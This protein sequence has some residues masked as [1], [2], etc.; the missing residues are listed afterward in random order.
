MDTASWRKD[1][2]IQTEEFFD[3]RV[4][5]YWNTLPAEVVQAASL[6]AFKTRLNKY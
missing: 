3:K 2:Q 6:N 4:H 1:V 5:N